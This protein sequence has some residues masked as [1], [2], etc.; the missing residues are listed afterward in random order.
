MGTS[1]DSNNNNDAS[2]KEEPPVQEDNELPESTL[3]KTEDESRLE[4]GSDS[5]S[6]AAEQKR[7]EQIGGIRGTGIFTV[8]DGRDPSTIALQV[9]EEEE[10]YIEEE[11]EGFCG[12]CGRPFNVGRPEAKCTACDIVMH[13]FCF[14]SHVIKSH[15]PVAVGVRITSREGKFFARMRKPEE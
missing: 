1:E 5:E 12:H 13:Q 15:K 11:I 9:A 10:N 6:D 2:Q 4:S 14:D 7:R 8:P 3:S